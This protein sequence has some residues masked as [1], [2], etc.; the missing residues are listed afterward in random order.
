VIESGVNET[1]PPE[2]IAASQVVETEKR[3]P[4]MNPDTI[5]TPEQIQLRAYLIAERRKN[6][7]IGGDENGDWA[8][9]ESELRA[10]GN[11]LQEVH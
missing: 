1:L 8:Q 3:A 11:L 6:S 9:A 7:G 5:A 2:D 10:E 4:K